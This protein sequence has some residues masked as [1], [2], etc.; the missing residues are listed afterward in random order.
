LLNIFILLLSAS[1]ISN[2]STASNSDHL[3]HKSVVSSL[4]RNAKP[5]VLHLTGGATLT[6]PGNSY[7][8]AAT[9]TVEQYLNVKT[10]GLDFAT[11]AIR[12]NASHTGG[13][14]G[15]SSS[16][17]R[18]DSYVDVSTTNYE[19]GITSR[20][21]NSS[22]AGQNVAGYFQGIKN[23]AGATWGAVIEVI[24][25]Y[26][27]NPVF[28]TIGLEVDVDCNG[29]DNNSARIGIDVAIR[30][31]DQTGAD[32]VASYGVRIQNNFEPNALVKTGYGFYTGM[33]T[34]LGFDASGAIH[35][36]GAFKA[37]EN[38]NF[39]WSAD[40]TQTMLNT[41]TALN[42]LV[43]GTTKLSLKWNGGIGLNSD[44]FI[45]AGTWS[46]GSSTPSLGSN[47]PGS[48][49]GGPAIWASVTI[50]GNQYW[51]PLWP[52]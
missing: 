2:N 8:G 23:A 45:V 4:L 5:V 28:S 30:K 14:P 16:T 38:Q 13:T 27:I 1:I 39:V 17:F 9:N 37:K 40:N 25:N 43:S 35:T 15:Y 51:T 10:T 33:K 20:L 41:G 42:L 49:S 34:F 50:D 19:W 3:D 18:V 21:S 32:A 26:G 46:T 29:A 24:D 31:A 6:G 44:R 22:A 48:T 52:N 47:L 11:Q 12:R 7:F 36:L